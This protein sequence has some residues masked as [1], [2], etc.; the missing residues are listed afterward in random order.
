MLT[1]IESPGW[2]E[3]HARRSGLRPYRYTG[4]EAGAHVRALLYLDRRG[5]VCLPDLVP[6]V[7][8]AFETARQRSSG[9]TAEWL[10]LTRPLAEEIRR[11]T[12]P[13]R[14]FLSAAVED[15]RPWQWAGLL[16]DVDYAYAID[17]PFNPALMD[18]GQRTNCAKAT[19]LGMRVERI[20]HP[21]PVIACLAESAARIGYRVRIDEAD[22]RTA[23]GL[24][25]VDGLRMYACFD[26]QGVPASACVVVHAPGSQAFGWLTGTRSER[27]ADGVNHL[28]WRTVIDD[29]ESAGAT[30]LDFGGPNSP[31]ISA[32]KSRWGARL[33]PIHSIRSY[34]F[35]AA[36][37]FCAD[38]IRPRHEPVRD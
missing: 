31:T 15:V 6:Y 18:R 32:F 24:L 38:W 13:R 17:L 36:A 35:R 25:G 5:R 27:L 14:V 34:S 2:V 7:A 23:R 33:M 28:L 9:R 16:V 4:D 11:R 19:R 30:G 22:L 10:R 29:I 26:P 21:G 1:A 3:F 37:R 8:V 20:D 12:V